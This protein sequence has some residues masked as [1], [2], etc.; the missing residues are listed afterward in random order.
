MH[1]CIDLTLPL[2][3]LDPMKSMSPARPAAQWPFSC[4]TLFCMPRAMSLCL[5][6]C[7]AIQLKKGKEFLDTSLK[8]RSHSHRHRIKNPPHSNTH[9]YTGI[10][11]THSNT[12]THVHRHNTHTDIPD[13][14]LVCLDFLKVFL[15]FL[16]FCP[17]ACRA[18]VRKEGR[19]SEDLK[20]LSID[21]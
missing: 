18:H 7:I 17:L 11:H 16:C 14:C 13:F 21:E 10:T 12:H 19:I 2:V 9:T 8:I 5:W 1:T 3:L 20:T 4:R 6:S 15:C